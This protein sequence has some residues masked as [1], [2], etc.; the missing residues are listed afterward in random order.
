[1][2]T[3]MRRSPCSAEIM[4]S[5]SSSAPPLVTTPPLLGL[6]LTRLVVGQLP[7]RMGSGSQLCTLATT[8]QE[9]TSSEGRC[10]RRV[11]HVPHVPPE[12]PAP[13]TSLACVQHPQIPQ[14]QSFQRT[15]PLL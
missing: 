5:H 11:L 9:A 13:Q 7:T 15:P 2:G 3:G 6:R 4:S 10:T 12:P 1:M 14:Q 8:V